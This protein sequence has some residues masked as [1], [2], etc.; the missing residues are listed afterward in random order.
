[1]HV[2]K[3]KDQEKVAKNG[4]QVRKKKERRGGEREG[5]DCEG[6]GDFS[7]DRARAWG[8]ELTEGRQRACDRATQVSH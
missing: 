6:V 7:G 5:V 2:R 3:K 1:M 4:N 8:G